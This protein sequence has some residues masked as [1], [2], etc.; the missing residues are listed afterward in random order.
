MRHLK[1]FLIFQKVL[2]GSA[3]EVPLC[4]AAAR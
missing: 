1:A 3:R 2:F 4:G